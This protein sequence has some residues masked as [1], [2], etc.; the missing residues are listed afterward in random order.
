VNGTAEPVGNQWP[1]QV[2]CTSA[3]QPPVAIE[4]W[5]DL[6][7]GDAQSSSTTPYIRWTWPMAF[8][9]IDQLQLENDFMLPQVKGFSRSNANFGDAY[10]DL[11]TGVVASP[12]GG[13]FYDDSVPTAVCGYSTSS[14]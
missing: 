11:P 13:Y 8:F 9:Q 1:S 4:V 7:V 2:T 12:T 3:S 14:T 10:K 5:S 6:W